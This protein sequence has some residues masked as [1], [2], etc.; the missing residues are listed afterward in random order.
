MSNLNITYITNWCVIGFALACHSCPSFLSI[1][2]V[3]TSFFL[4]LFIHLHK[5]PQF[6][7]HL[8]DCPLIIPFFVWFSWVSLLKKQRTFLVSI[9]L[10]L[11]MMLIASYILLLLRIWSNSLETLLLQSR[12]STWKSFG[13]PAG[14]SWGWN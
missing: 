9:L 6:C 3:C 13:N 11:F 12:S 4:F 1:L 8:W 10:S 7:A 2:P 5:L 14:P